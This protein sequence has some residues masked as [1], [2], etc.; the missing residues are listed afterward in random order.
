MESISR[1]R[2]SLHLILVA[3]PL[4]R[5]IFETKCE[6][7]E[8]KNAVDKKDFDEIRFPGQIDS[9]LGRWYDKIL[10][11]MRLCR[12]LCRNTPQAEYFAERMI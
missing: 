3:D 12:L 8:L 9:V 7:S 10:P 2:A 11:I 5:D 4:R 1:S 6:L